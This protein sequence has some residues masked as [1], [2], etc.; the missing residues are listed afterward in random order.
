MAPLAKKRMHAHM[1]GRLSATR[2]PSLVSS[3]VVLIVGLL[4]VLHS[5]RDIQTSIRPIGTLRQTF[6]LVQ[7]SNKI[8]EEQGQQENKEEGGEIREIEG[9]ENQSRLERA[10]NQSRL[11]VKPK[12]PL[13][14]NGVAHSDMICQPEMD[15]HRD[16]GKDGI[17][18]AG[19]L[20]CYS[21][22]SAGRSMHYLCQGKNWLGQSTVKREGFLSQHCVSGPRG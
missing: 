22:T 1:E 11:E 12:A 7:E 4:T 6:N 15:G 2:L 10:E 9:A 20:A 14:T 19:S 16:E 18:G 13:E 8:R 5:L 21:L 17:L 3:L